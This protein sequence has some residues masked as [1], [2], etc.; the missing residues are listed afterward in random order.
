[1]KRSFLSLIVASIQIGV[2]GC[3]HIH[4]VQGPVTKSE[5]PEGI[6]VGIG[7]K[8]VKEGDRVIVVN[9][10]CKLVFK[11]ARAGKMNEC[12]YEKTGEAVVLKVLDHD[13][14]IVRPDDGVKIET[15]MTVEKK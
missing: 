11:G 1:M 8:E 4:E 15:G 2:A 5:T 14:A 13:S 6:Q 12:H 10:V 9:S 3:G 7:G